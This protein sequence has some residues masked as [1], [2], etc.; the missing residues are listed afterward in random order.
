VAQGVEHELVNVTKVYQQG[1]RTVEAVRG[2][3]LR[4]AAGEFLAIMGPSGSGKS[5]LLHLLGA[6][7]TPTSGQ[8]YF[9]GQDLLAMTDRQRAHLRRTKIGFVF[10]FFNLLPTLTAVENVA[11][12]LLLGGVG[13][14]A[15]LA[16]AEAA[17][18]RVSLSKRRH[19]F[20][21]EMSGGEMQR[22]AIAR[23]LVAEP[24][25]VLCDE[26]TGNLDS[27]T[28][29]EILALLR[30]LP[31]NGKRA[32]VMVTHD[33]AAAEVGDRIVHMHDGLVALAEDAVPG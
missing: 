5:T 18:D 17:L 13:R 21:E 6:L 9:H 26:P 30:Q 7:D 8:V 24:E 32:V 14:R 23:A 15:A 1:R 22:T 29:K 12:P 28:S 10:Q 31:E 27:A 4:V 19:H 2:V 20:P 33:P 25:A 3:S 16:R 11:M